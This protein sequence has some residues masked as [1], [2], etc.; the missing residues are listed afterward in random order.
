M[1]KR[2]KFDFIN[3]PTLTPETMVLGAT[4]AEWNRLFTGSFVENLKLD[5]LRA[6]S[7]KDLVAGECS[8][9]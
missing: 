7:E 4:V 1:L 9:I 2:K 3:I 5:R 8:K 6:E